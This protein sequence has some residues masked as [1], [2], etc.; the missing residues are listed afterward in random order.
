MRN[1]SHGKN[2]GIPRGNVLENTKK[3]SEEN[4][5]SRAMGN[6][7]T[8]PSLPI[9]PTTTLFSEKRTSRKNNHTSV[10]FMVFLSIV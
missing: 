10:S 4:V 1:T 9:L 8:R 5:S 2:N 6:P 3:V 7:G